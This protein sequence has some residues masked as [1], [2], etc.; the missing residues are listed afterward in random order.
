MIAAYLKRLS[1]ALEFDPALAS[2]VVAET[3]EHLFDAADQESIDDREEAERRAVD[4]FGDPRALA[5]QFAAIS[6]ARHAR[7]VGV[8]VILAIV[9]IMVMMKTRVAWY[10]FVQWT[11]ADDARATAAS[12]HSISRYSFWLAATL[13]I[14]TLIYIGRRRTPMRLHAGYRRHLRCIA[15]LLACATAAL[16]VSVIGDLI[17]TGLR[18]EMERS[19][20][21]V[22]PIASLSIEI[23]SIAI[24]VFMIANA[25]RRT[26]QMARL[27]GADA[28]I[29]TR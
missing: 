3:R 7:R 14:G 26:A 21:A 23:A 10:A 13:G 22:I 29:R 11:L 28:G 9:T 12:I 8:G 2:H 15:C 5:A 27:F 18:I 25:S 17:L 6:L 19:A 16:A 24:L 1:D 4:R 20:E